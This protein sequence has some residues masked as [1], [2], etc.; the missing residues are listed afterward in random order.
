MPVP[1]AASSCARR[2]HHAPVEAVDVD[3]AAIEAQRAIDA[4][5]RGWR[6]ELGAARYDAMKRALRQLGRDQIG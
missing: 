2:V 5:E 4:V 3:A 6:A 1:T